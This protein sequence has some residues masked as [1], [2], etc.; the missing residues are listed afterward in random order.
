MLRK[1]LIAAFAIDIVL[2]VFPGGHDQM[3]GVRDG[4]TFVLPVLVLGGA[5]HPRRRPGLKP[6][7]SPPPHVD[8]FS[9]TW[10]A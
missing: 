2:I 3:P 10:A 4:A 1:A 8:R 7:G 9:G 5:Q 6:A